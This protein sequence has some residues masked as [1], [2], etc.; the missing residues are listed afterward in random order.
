TPFSSFAGQSGNGHPWSPAHDTG[1]P[2]R[3]RPLGGWKTAARPSPVP[4]RPEGRGDHP[5]GQPPGSSRASAP[6]HGPTIR[7]ADR[8]GRRGRLGCVA[9][10][11]LGVGKG[12]GSRWIMN[13]AIS[14][15]EDSLRW[16]LE[17]AKQAKETAAAK[18]GSPEE[19][20]EVGRS[21]ALA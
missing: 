17:E 3:S 14:C 21:E 13:P 18:R 20:F 2:H 9:V 10:I 7:P 4:G 16:L 19:A 11:I 6:G 1:P 8:T 15:I 5:P 12:E